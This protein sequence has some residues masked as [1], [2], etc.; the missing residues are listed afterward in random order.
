M[1]QTYDGV[2]QTGIKRPT[3]TGGRISELVAENCCHSGG[4]LFGGLTASKDCPINIRSK[5][6]A[7]NCS[8]SGSFDGRAA[9][10]WHTCG[11]PLMHSGSAHAK[12]PGDTYISAKDVG[13][14]I[15]CVHI[16]MVSLS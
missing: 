8:I 5:I 7:A 4:L 11:F 15:K 12:E 14:L 6:L 9:L 2:C 16:H 10:C 13:C 3:R 1:K